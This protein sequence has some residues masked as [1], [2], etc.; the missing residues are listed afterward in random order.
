MALRQG[1]KPAL[2]NRLVEEPSV[3]TWWGK[4]PLLRWGDNDPTLTHQLGRDCKGWLRLFPQPGCQG[5]LGPGPPSSKDNVPPQQHQ[6]PGGELAR[7]PLLATC[8]LVQG[9]C[10]YM[11]G[12]NETQPSHR[13]T[14]AGS[15]DGSSGVQSLTLKCFLDPKMETTAVPT[16]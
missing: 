10:S 6:E 9:T 12:C 13:K 8:H 1:A 11:P 15:G 2:C 3:P 5:D 7:Q 14:G 4:E 16:N